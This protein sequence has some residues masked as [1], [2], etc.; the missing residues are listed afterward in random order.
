[1]YVSLAPGMEHPVGVDLPMENVAWC[2]Q[3]TS[4]DDDADQVALTALDRG[5][6]KRP[7]TSGP[8]RGGGSP[9]EM[10]QGPSTTP[11]SPAAP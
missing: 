11:S 3:Y 4:S 2:Y 1:M 7:M 5:A 9:S 8:S 6:G 10:A